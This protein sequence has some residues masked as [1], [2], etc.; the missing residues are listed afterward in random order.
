MNTPVK[1]GFLRGSWYCT[2]NAPSIAQKDGVISDPMSGIALMLQSVRLGDIIYI[3]NNANY[4]KFVNDGTSKMRGHH[5]VEKAVARA[6]DIA[7]KV[8]RES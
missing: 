4:A 2:L 1:T 5:M 3:L 8:T 6:G 7:Q